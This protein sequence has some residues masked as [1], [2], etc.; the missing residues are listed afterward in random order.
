M[1]WQDPMDDT[2]QKETRRR[3]KVCL[4]A[5][6]KELKSRGVSV[7]RQD[8]NTL[9]VN[10]MTFTATDQLSDTYNDV[11]YLLTDYNQMIECTLSRIEEC[12][13]T[14]LEIEDVQVEKMAFS[15]MVK[16]KRKSNNGLSK[17]SDYEFLDRLI[18]DKAENTD[19]GQVLD[20][21]WDNTLLDRYQQ[22]Y[23]YIL[24]LQERGEIDEGKFNRYMDAGD[25]MI[26]AHDPMVARFNAMR[27]KAYGFPDILS[28]DREVVAFYMAVKNIPPSELLRF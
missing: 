2:Q 14:I 17:E 23:D 10:G 21:A 19:F 27:E 3:I 24:G 15:D 1:A 18:Q 28:S 26:V 25:A 22:N 5:L 12:A 20:E 7:T 4:E 13:D 8:E 11:C 6:V 9:V 16:K